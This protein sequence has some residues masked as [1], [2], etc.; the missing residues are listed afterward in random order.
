MALS[1]SI[2]AITSPSRKLSPSRFSHRPMV[3][4]SIVSERRGIVSSSDMGEPY[5]PHSA[6]NER[7]AASI[8]DSSGSAASSSGF[9]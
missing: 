1:V 8:F 7:A 3:P 6:S 9:A 5:S 4:C 2:S